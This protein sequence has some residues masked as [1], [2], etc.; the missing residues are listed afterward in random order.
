M[1]KLILFTVILLGVFIALSYAQ[2]AKAKVIL[3]VAE[4]NI[5]GP[6]HAWWVSEVDLSATEAAIARRLI[7]QGY[8]VL[9]PSALTRIIKQKPAF[10]ILALSEQKSVKLGNLSKADYVLLGK[11]VASAGAGVPQSSM[12][13]CFAN[14]T[15]KLIRVKDGRVVAYLDASGN[16]AHMDVITGGREALSSMGDNLAVK[17]IEALNKEGGK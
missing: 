15:A 14:T 16:S 12:R 11:A 7:A 3:L 8:E 9:E 17:L 1:K 10:R 4:Q 2:A 6:Q 5:E 13:S